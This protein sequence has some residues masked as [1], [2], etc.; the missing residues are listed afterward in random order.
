MT[1]ISINTTLLRGLHLPRLRLLL[2]VCL[3]HALLLWWLTHAGGTAA[4]QPPD[5]EPR[6]VGRLVAAGAAPSAATTVSRP[7]RQVPP[8]RPTAQR[9]APAPTRPRVAPRSSTAAA[10]TA[11]AKTQASAAAATPAQ[12]VAQPATPQGGAGQV[13]L[14]V[15]R[16]SGLDNPLPVYPAL[17]RRQGEEGVVRLSVLIL[18]DGSVAEVA[19]QKSSGFPRLDAA[20]VAAVRQWH[21]LP[22]RRNGEAIAWRHT[23]PVAF[24][25]NP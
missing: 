20:A 23:Q 10:S 4:P 24:T 19:V 9:Q 25:L 12:A 14:P 2:S 21:Y 3:A 6:V 7:Q 22:A 18:A 8:P 17:S 16:A 5:R 15:S 1:R 11:Q 13:Q